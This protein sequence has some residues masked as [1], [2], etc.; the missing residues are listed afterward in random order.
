MLCY[1]EY[2]EKA[3]RIYRALHQ[4]PEIGFELEKTVRIVKD[5]LEE[6][7]I[8]YT[9]RYGRGSIVAELGHGER[10]IALRADMD[11]LPIEENSG[12][13]FS[14]L[15]RGTMHA[16]GHD[17]HTAVLLAVAGFLK[18]H[19]DRLGVRVRLLF[20]PAEECS[21]S[22]AR[23]ML[24]NGVMDGVEQVLAAHCTPELPAFTIGACKGNYM[25]ACAPL[26]IT[27]RGRSSHASLPKQGIDAIA[28]ANQVYAELK[29]AVSREANGA[30]YIWNVGRMEG[31]RAHN[32]ICDRCE[33]DISFR[34]YDA[35]FAARMETQTKEICARIAKEYG[36]EIDVNWCV[37]TGPVINDG[38]I[39]NALLDGC[40]R[41]GIAT[42]E[43]RPVMSSED[44]GWYLTRAR[45]CLFRFGIGDKSF[46][47]TKA[48]HTTDF[49]IYEPAMKTAIVT[50]CEYVLSSGK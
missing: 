19:E 24:E 12:L 31:G 30:A 22:G 39:V 44:F 33:M 45:G 46:G 9:E 40:S 34:F 11:A 3:V 5:V 47:S 32:V 41:R 2:Y 49:K 35:D 21:V 6:Y 7:G 36:G 18:E 26:R 10:C 43:I 28:M 4:V 37:S 17:S 23:M 29:T 20:Q 16:C 14:S 15:H 8:A 27:C 38:A 50:F 42:C 13:A 25:A 1:N 48:L